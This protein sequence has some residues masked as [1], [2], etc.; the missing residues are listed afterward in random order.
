MR[1][2][3]LL[4]CAPASTPDE[5]LNWAPW[6]TARTPLQQGAHAAWAIQSIAAMLV[7]RTFGASSTAQADASFREADK[8]LATREEVL[9]LLEDS[10]A[11]YLQRLDALTPELLA[12]TIRVTVWFGPR[13]ARS[14]AEF[15]A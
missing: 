7:G 5:R 9:S 8:Q 2:K 3:D 14:R 4:L 15:R 6:P 13:A 11:A 10:S 12:G 1:A